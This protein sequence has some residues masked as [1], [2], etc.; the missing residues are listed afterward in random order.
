M[1]SLQQVEAREFTY[2]SAFYPALLEHRHFIVM[3][4]DRR[5][6]QE[7]AEAFAAQQWGRPEHV[8]VYPRTYVRKARV[9]FLAGLHD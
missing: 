3:T 1:A 2:C 5:E 7:R 4:P 6:A 8:N 9:A